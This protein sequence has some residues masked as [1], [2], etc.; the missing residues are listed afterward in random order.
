MTG[1]FVADDSYL[2]EYTTDAS[3]TSLD[4]TAVTG[5][6][7]TLPWSESNRV[8]YLPADAATTGNN[9][10]VGDVCPH[11]S[12]SPE[13][14]DFRPSK[15]FEA[16]QATFT[17]QIDG[18]RLLMLPFAAIL[19]EGVKAY[20][21]GTDM[22][23]TEVESISAHQPVLVEAQG[24]ITLTGSGEVSYTASS[25]SDFMRGSY[26]QRSL[27]AGDYLLGQQNGE[28]G[29]IRQSK[30][31]QL[32]PFGVYAQPSSTA[33]FLPLDFSAMGIESVG[34]A[35]MQRDMPVYNVMG[36]R[37]GPDYK[38]IVIVGGKKMW[39]R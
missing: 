13:G 20:T 38:G 33:S 7:A 37:V 24:E 19:P 23:L 9:L 16:S 26:T 6:P 22:V 28:W 25:L 5:L 8:V 27:Y 35:P 34:M 1:A 11:L 4:M 3:C 32:Q 12:L 36:Q 14:G 2:L 10:V 18:Y 39:R 31:A 21:I 30:A 29:L 15:A 17:C